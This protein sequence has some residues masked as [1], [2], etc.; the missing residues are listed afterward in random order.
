MNLA[1]WASVAIA[2]PA[3]VLAARWG[4]A[5]VIYGVGIGWLLRALTAFYLTMRHLQLPAKVPATAP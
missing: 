2:V 4:L 3:A 5:G 1:G